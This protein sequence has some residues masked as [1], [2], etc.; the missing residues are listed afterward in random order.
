V[1][2]ELAPA[3]HDA[4]TAEARFWQ[5][6][7]SSL[8][9]VHGFLLRRCDRQ[10]AEDLTQEVY[11]DLVRRVRHGGDPSGFTTG[12]LISV[13][14][15]RLI[16]HMRAQQRRERK[17]SMAWSAADAGNREGVAVDAATSVDLGAAT[18]RAL[19]ELAEVERCVLVMHHLDGSSVAEI[20]D[21]IGRSQRAT[22][23]LL[24]RARRKFRAAFE[25]TADA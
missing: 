2:D 18:E 20:A 7:A 11:V 8:P 4:S 23:S 3:E 5:L 16:D 9:H 21:A 6:Y 24:A 25:E 19:G 13:A 15:S 10:T 14:R 17:L 12:W 22:E 1:T